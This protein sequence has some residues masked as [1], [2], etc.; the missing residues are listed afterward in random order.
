M[1][2][3]PQLDL[4]RLA[5]EVREAYGLDARSFEL[6]RG[7]D[8]FSV[9]YR[10]DTDI[11]PRFL[12]VLLRRPAATPLAV[13]RAIKEAGISAVVPP[14]PAIGGSLAHATADGSSLVLYPYV[15]GSNAVSRTMSAD[16]WRG[17]GA[18]LRAVHDSPL[19][20]RFRGLLPA[21]PFAMPWAPDLR[22]ILAVGADPPL[23]SGAAARM[24]ALLGER[25]KV[26]ERMLRRAEELAGRLRHRPCERVLC[27][28]DIHAANLL[29]ADDGRVLMVD[30]DGPMLAPRERDLL[31]VIGSRIARRVEPQ[32]EAW[33][34]EG[35]GPVEIDPEALVFF[36]HER[37]LEDV[38]IDAESI[39]SDP[40]RDEAA[41]L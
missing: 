33:F 29:V 12:K 18:A 26:L 27:H 6:R 1:L 19:A 24:A 38:A 32:E 9:A 23:R 41:A 14:I 30:W 20:A 3:D 5:R 25:A 2:E 8:L 13:P 34:F 7:H 22:R 37:I 35:Y 31:F 28:A 39:L 21:E 15:A 4:G 40:R 36:R 17:F 11:G 16:Q 10:I